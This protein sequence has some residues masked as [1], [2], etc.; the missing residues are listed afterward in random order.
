MGR[1]DGLFQEAEEVLLLHLEGENATLACVFVGVSG[2][3]HHP[4]P[5]W[6]D[7]GHAA[8]VEVG[9]CIEFLGLDGGI[10]NGRFVGLVDD[11]VLTVVGGADLAVGNFGRMRHG[12]VVK[13]FN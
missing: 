8:G 13:R 12:C 11:D 10:G 6:F 9:R 3:V 2:A 7:P 4:A 5:A 1:Q